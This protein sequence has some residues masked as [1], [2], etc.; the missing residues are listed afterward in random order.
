MPRNHACDGPLSRPSQASTDALNNITKERRCIAPHHAV[1]TKVAQ[2]H[3][4][5]SSSRGASP[6]VAIQDAEEGAKGDKK[7]HK[8]RCQEA[9]TDDDSGINERASG[10]GVG[11][12]T[13]VA[14]SSNR[15]ARPP[16]DHIEK[17]LEE[18]YP[19][20]AYPIKHKLRDCDMMNN[21]IT[22]GSLS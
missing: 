4:A 6:N 18:A 20:H 22:S 7:R 15:Q 16:M 11:R 13:K 9:A 10:S 5:P 14:G 21:F 12:T 2:L 17:L 19:N 3:P 1:N 8:Q